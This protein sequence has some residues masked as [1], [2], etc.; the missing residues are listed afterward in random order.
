MIHPTAIVER[1]AEL[2]GSVEVGPFAYVGRHVRLGPGC[3]LRPRATVVGHTTAGRDCIFFPGCVIGE[4]PQD[5]KYR[6]EQTETIIGDDNHFRENVTVHSGTGIGGGQ[7]I[8]GS[9]NRFLVGVHLAHD[10]RAGNHIVVSNNVQIA[11]H[12][13]I[14]DFVTMGGQTAIHHFVTVGRYA[15]IGGMSRV[16]CDC[17]PYMTT[18]GY[19][20]EVRSVNTVGLQRW[21]VPDAD[22]ERL[23]EAYRMLYSRRQGDGLT[24]V[25]RLQRLES[26]ASSCTTIRSLCEFLRRSLSAGNSGRYLES[27]RQDTREHNREFFEKKV[28][29][30]DND[31]GA[32]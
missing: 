12:V 10:V 3:Q 27:Q 26:T 23:W 28:T 20:A 32:I 11:G 15:M 1:G 17:P 21:Q 30:E 2:D 5:L 24:F 7:T 19:P 4:I 31:R 18:T 13:H 14:E 22:I 9:H 29:R 16:T 6:G 25:E 8:I